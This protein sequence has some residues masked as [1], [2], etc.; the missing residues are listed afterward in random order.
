[1]K[2]EVEWTSKGGRETEPG[3]GGARVEEAKR[4]SEIGYVDET[5]LLCPI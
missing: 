3:G 2:G 1:M 5:F 4:V